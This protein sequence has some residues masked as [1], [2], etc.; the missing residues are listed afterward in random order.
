MAGDRELRMK[1]GF[2]LAAE[3]GRHE[4]RAM[5]EA[6]GYQDDQPIVVALESDTVQDVFNRLQKH[7]PPVVV[8]IFWPETSTLEFTQL[9]PA[10]QPSDYSADRDDVGGGTTIGM[11]WQHT[12]RQQNALY[13]FKLNWGSATTLKIERFDRVPA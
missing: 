7:T 12:H 10:G 8:A 4:I 13:R 5:F 2:A 11:L 9:E 3:L 6:H 1:A